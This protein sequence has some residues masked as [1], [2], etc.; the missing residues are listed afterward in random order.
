[1]PFHEIRKLAADAIAAALEREF[2][3]E[4]EGI[5]LEVPPR[6][7]LGD[8]AWPGALPL[9]KVLRRA[10][11]RDRRD[12]GRPRPRGRS[13]STGSRS[14][15]RASS[16]CSSTAGAAPAAAAREPPRAGDRQR[17]QDHRRAHQ[18]QPQQGGPHRPPAQRRARRHP[19]ALPARAA[20]RRSRSRTTS[21][22]PASRW[23]T[24]W[25]ACS[26]CPRTSWPRRSAIEIARRDELIGRFVERLPRRRRAGRRRPTT[27][28]T[29]A[30]RSTRRVTARYEA[31]PEFAGRRAE[32]LHAIEGGP[33]DVDLEQADLPRCG[34]R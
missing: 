5:S 11:P 24:W 12:G 2:D 7:E 29:C 18:H 25:S 27:S 16:T 34:A 26:T 3:H 4:A 8:L 9:A 21:T 31:D 1:M 22:T 23:P 33:G 13:E 10:A 30:G 14:P 15:A 20:A 28:T 17:R 19:G 6:R 32:V